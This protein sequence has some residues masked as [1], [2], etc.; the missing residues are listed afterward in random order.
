MKKNYTAPEIG[1]FG[2]SATDIITASGDTIYRSDDI[3]VINKGDC[4]SFD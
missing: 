2:F 1:I 4:V 3:G